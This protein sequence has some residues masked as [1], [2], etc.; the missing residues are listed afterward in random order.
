MNLASFQDVVDFV[1]PL[2]PTMTE[3]DVAD[4]IETIRENPAAG[5]DLLEAYKAAAD[6]TTPADVWDSIW[7]ALQIAAKAASVVTSLAGAVSLL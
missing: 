6:T 1:L 3:R 5:P 2:A 7:A 4:L